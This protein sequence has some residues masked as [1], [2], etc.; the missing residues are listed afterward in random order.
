MLNLRRIAVLLSVAALSVSAVRADVVSYFNFDSGT[1]VNSQLTP[2]VS[3]SP[4]AVSGKYGQGM[5]FALDDRWVITGDQLTNFLSSIDKTCTVSFWA[6]SNDDTVSTGQYKQAFWLSSSEAIDANLAANSQNYRNMFTHYAYSN[7]S[8][9]Y[10]DSGINGYDRVN[11]STSANT[12]P[13]DE[14]VH[15]AYVKDANAGTMR[16]YRNGVELVSGTNKNRSIEGIVAMTIANNLSVQMDDFVVDNKALGSGEVLALAT[17]QTALVSDVMNRSLSNASMEISPGGIGTVGTM[18]FIQQQNMAYGRGDYASQINIAGGAGANRAVDG[19]TNTTWGG[20]SMIH[21]NGGA[22]GDWWQVQFSDT[23]VPVD[24]VTIWNRTEGNGC[25]QR[26]GNFTLNFYTEDP[27]ANADAA[28]V[29]SYHYSGIF[30]GGQGSIDIPD[31]FNANWVRITNGIAQ[32]LNISE[33]QIYT[34][35]DNGGFSAASNNGAMIDGKNYQSYNLTLSDNSV[36]TMDVDGANMDKLSVSGALVQGGTVKFNFIDAS[37]VTAADITNMISANSCSGGF[38][39]II[40]TGDDAATFD[41]KDIIIRS[42][43]PNKLFAEERVHW[44]AN[45]EDK[46]FANVNNWSSDPTN[47]EVAVG[48]Y[49][50]EAA[51][52]TLNTSMS[53]GYVH[54]AQSQTVGEASL[55]LNS[56]ANLSVTG[57]SL[58]ENDEA[59][60]TVNS[61]A[62]F[63]DTGNLIVGHG[64]YATGTLNVDGG[65]VTVNKLRVGDFQTSKGYVNITNGEVTV[66]SESEIGNHGVAEITVSNNGKLTFKSVVRIA[67]QGKN[68]AFINLE[69]NAEMS[70]Q[71]L[72]VGQ[73]GSN[74][75]SM[76]LS[77]DSKLTVTDHLE[78]GTDSGSNGSGTITLKGNAQVKV[79]NTGT[80]RT[81]IGYNAGTSTLNVSDNATFTVDGYSFLVADSATG[82]IN[83][84]GGTININTNNPTYTGDQTGG[85]AIF[86][87]SGGQFN[88]NNQFFAGTRGMSTINLSG[89]GEFNAN[90]LFT[91]A[92]GYA[93]NSYSYVNQTGGTFNAKAGIVYGLNA[94]QGS[95]VYNLEAGT[96]NTP[97]ITR[98]DGYNNL[99]AQFYMS[100][101][102]ANIDTLAIPAHVSGGTLNAGTIDTTLSYKDTFAQSGGVLTIGG[103]DAI[104]TTT[105]TGSYLATTPIDA[106]N[107]GRTGTAFQ[108]SNYNTTF[109][110]SLA[111][112]GNYNDSNFSHTSGSNVAHYWGVSYGED[113]NFGKVV[114]YNRDFEGINSRLTDGVGF[115]VDVLDA[116][117]NVVWQSQTYKGGGHKG[118]IVDVPYD[119]TGQKVRVVRGAATT[120][121]LNLTEVEVFAYSSEIDTSNLPTMKFEIQNPNSYDQLVLQGDSFDIGS[122]LAALDVSSLDPSALHT[123][124]GS[125]TLF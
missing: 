46:N 47:K 19:N 44:L 12:Y 87:I 51:N 64:D 36:L 43:A 54:F 26:L 62:T 82:V 11:T 71:H 75:G 24:K 48:L 2:T 4:T 18:R 104:G 69:D 92:P 21:T 98:K 63:T 49:G 117:D 124:K 81:R 111:I 120:A 40:I 108:D 114:I 76:T 107:I 109:L 85:K 122:G 13:T 37:T 72:F 84:T 116:D 89:N 78:I 5:N 125:T 52:M 97:S 110:P 29:Y 99:N 88:V 42:V 91:G 7:G 57:M 121:P 93:L 79:T 34:P 74:L 28:P 90:Q 73:R 106:T 33:V 16:V 60:M 102:V 32:P 38:K 61:G 23:A 30:P 67:N 86:N 27:S 55:T 100:G 10:F 50:D 45:P 103:T 96:L 14:W 113:V 80:N 83:Q 20:G 77:G 119:V 105:I 25:D 1:Y 53:L 65:T 101:G 68:A 70:V 39:E 56:G 22:V 15:W 95:G 66:N 112:D 17:S 9:I 115:Y 123:P 31:T 118:F 58:G 8:A 35:T 3:G 94:N 59:S 6:K 41:K